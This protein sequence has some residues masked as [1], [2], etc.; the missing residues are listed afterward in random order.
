MVLRV[1]RTSPTPPPEARFADDEVFAACLGLS[2][3]DPEIQ[4]EIDA[5]L[6]LEAAELAEQKRRRREERERRRERNAERARIATRPRVLLMIYD[7][8]SFTLEGIKH[9]ASSNGHGYRH[10]D[11]AGHIF[12]L[13][14]KGA[15]EVSESLFSSI[16]RAGGFAIARARPGLKIKG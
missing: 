7:S 15:Q 13:S 12:L 10:P 16:G 6:A 14:W 9:W 8:R 11:Y 2:L 5:D 3:I 1:S 4:K